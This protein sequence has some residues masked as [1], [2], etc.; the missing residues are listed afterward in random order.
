MYW[1]CER[2][3]GGGGVY[4]IMNDIQGGGVYEI[5]NDIQ[6]GGGCMRLW[7]TCR[8]GGGGV[9][10]YERHTGGG[11]VRIWKNGK[12]QLWV[13]TCGKWKFGGT[14]FLM[15]KLEVR[16]C[17]MEIKGGFGKWKLVAKNWKLWVQMYGKCESGVLIHRKLYWWWLV[18]IFIKYHK[19]QVNEYSINT[20]AMCITVVW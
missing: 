13:N 8:V 5:M 2:H 4:E 17:K 15:W 11:G 10:D 7:T 14:H 19:T 3:T 1:A 9:W 16:I 6:G 20:Y 18:V 12:K